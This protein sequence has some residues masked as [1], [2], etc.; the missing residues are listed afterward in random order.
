MGR[1]VSCSAEHQRYATIVVVMDDRVRAVCEMFLPESREFVGLHEYDGIVQDLSPAGVSAGLARLGTAGAHA[2]MD[3][4]TKDHL[5]AFEARARVVYGDLQQH[6]RSPFLH[7]FNLD[8]ACYDRAYAD[9]EVRRDAR[10]RHLAGWPDAVDAALE[11]LEAVPRPVAAGLL[12]A[13]RGLAAGMN[14]ETADPLVASACAAHQRLVARVAE[15]AE[16]GDPDAA[17]GAQGLARLMGAPEAMT[18]DVGRLAVR[19]ERE[20]NRLN[21]MLAHACAHLAP[22]EPIEALIERLH[23]DHPDADGVISEAALQVEEVLA[24]TRER[25]LTPYADGECLVGTA[26]PSRRWGMAM[27]SPAG[28]YEDDGPSWYHVTPPDPAWPSDQQENWLSVF[29]ATTLPV[30]TV[31]E[32]A[33]G[34]FA[35]GRCLRRAVGDVRRALQSISFLEGWAHYSEELCL[36]EGFRGGDPRFAIGVA[37]E[38]LVRVTRLIVALGLHTGGMTMDEAVHRFQADARLAGPAA[39]SEAARA[40]FDPGYGCYTF[41]KLEILALRDQAQAQWGV[42]YSHRRFHAAMLELGSPPL[43][44]IGSIL[45]NE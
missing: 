3:P 35:H 31:H 41:G 22:D 11:S 36:E 38:A 14:D 13:V 16:N 42:Q 34:H 24:F 12:E 17:I 19:A 4:V 23:H 43:G 6:R 28:P 7:L 32:V 8:L 15:F 18:V 21:E 39:R 10:R 27:L 45:G 40:S 2:V 26:P 44:L 25:G 9:P 30:I 29:S 1:A 37:L 33:P 20:R 5:A